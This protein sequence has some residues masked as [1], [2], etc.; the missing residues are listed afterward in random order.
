[1]SDRIYSVTDIGYL[2]DI[3]VAV[4][5]DDQNYK[6]LPSSFLFGFNKFALGALGPVAQ[7]VRAHA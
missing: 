7:V 6:T 1:M 5:A 4:V 3:S 2:L